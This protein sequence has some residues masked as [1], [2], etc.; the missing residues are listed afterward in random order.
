MRYTWTQAIVDNTT[1]NIVVHLKDE[2]GETGD[3]LELNAFEADAL[4]GRLNVLNATRMRMKA[5]PKKVKTDQKKDNIWSRMK[6][7]KD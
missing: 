1:M 6:R 2:N 4:A 3:T 7:G 5:S